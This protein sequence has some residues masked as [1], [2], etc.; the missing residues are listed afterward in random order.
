MNQLLTRRRLIGA[1]LLLPLLTLPGCVGGVLFP[2]YEEAIRRLLTVSSQR[3]FARLLEENGFFAHEVARVTLPPELGGNGA[4]TLLAALLQNEEISARLLRQVNAAA[5]S[6]ADAAAPVVLDA[7]RGLRV[8]D[9]TAIVRGG[10]TAATDYLQERMGGALFEAM[11]PEVG[12]ALRLFDSDIVTQALRSATGIDFE[13]LRYDVT[14]KASLG[15]YRA[16]A[17][18][19]AAIRADP[20]ETGDA[21]LTGVFGPLGLI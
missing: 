12:E 9:A 16:I 1:G 20:A 15:I 17:R 5:G 6:A 7:I 13:E 11:L 2:D 4:T 8:A 19:E 3:A 10:S 21:L 18:E 14:R